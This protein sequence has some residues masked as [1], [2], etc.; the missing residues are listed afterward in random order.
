MNLNINLANQSINKKNGQNHMVIEICP[1]KIITIVPKPNAWV[2]VID[3]SSSMQQTLGG[4]MN[5]TSPGVTITRSISEYNVSYPKEVA[6]KMEYAKSS[7]ISFLNKLTEAD[8]VGVVEFNSYANL[9]QELAPLSN[10]KSIISRI[11]EIKPS[12]CTNIDAGINLGRSLFSKEDLAKYNCK[13]I[14]LSDGETNEGRQTPEELSTMTL[15]FL[16]DGITTS[17]LGIGDDYNS[18]LLNKM[19][20]TGGGYLYHVNTLEKLE[21]IFTDELTLSNS[22][23]AKSVELEISYPEYFE[24]EQNLNNYYEEETDDGK[25]IFVG[26]LT[27]NRKVAIGFKNN[28]RTEDAT[29]KIKCKYKALNDFDYTIE[30]ETKVKVVEDATKEEKNM[31]VVDYI[32][33]LIKSNTVSEAMLFAENRDMC[34]VN[35]V[36]AKSVNCVSNMA[37]S[38]GLSNN[39]T[40]CVLD[41]VTTAQAECNDATANSSTSEIKASYSISSNST[42]Q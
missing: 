25:K 1:E 42:R 19:A 41:S 22:I 4:R 14:L 39:Y 20:T 9:V 11:E 35:N 29:F 7:I 6:T 2:F 15:S 27:A 18:Y 40:R 33:S 34:S 31:E 17:C 26:D 24:I 10:K 30:T 38:Y 37:S 23:L 21:Q 12:G 8:K 32:M 5:Y 13:I 36:F 3:K 16:K 28:H